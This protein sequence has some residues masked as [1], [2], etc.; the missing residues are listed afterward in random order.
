MKRAIVLASALAVAAGACKKSEEARPEAET[1]ADTQPTEAEPEAAATLTVYSGRSEKL[2]APA[3]AAFE[4]AAEID[5]EIKYADT[6]QLAATLMEE[7]ERSPAD[8]FIAQDASTL[9]FL[10]GKGVFAPLPEELVARVPEGFRAADGSWIGLSGRARVLAYNTDELEEGDLPATI[11]DLTKPAWKGRVGWAP[12]NASFQSFVAAMIELRGPEKTKAWLEAM[13]KN[14]P[15]DYPK[16]TPAVMAVSRGEVDVA[17]VN[18]YYLYR[19]KEE[20]GD[21]FPVANHYFRTGDAAALVN[22]SGAGVLKSSDDAEAA[23]E[24]LAYLLGAEGQEHF[25]AGNHEFPAAQGAASPDELP[26][27]DS[28]KAP[29]LDP[30]EIGNLEEAVAL[31]RETGVLK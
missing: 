27:I 4:E 29:A 20:H 26:S 19:L 16:N 22:L 8:V 1:A 10:A 24:L 21:D 7:G 15:K 6:A 12:E 3:L 9:A 2:I 30:A 11:D 25:V 28:L 13:K 14:Q 5:L 23:H 31:L 18:H 17:L